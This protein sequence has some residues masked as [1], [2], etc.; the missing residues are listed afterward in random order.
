MHTHLLRGMIVLISVL[1]LVLFTSQA[2]ADD[3]RVDWYE[4]TYVIKCINGEIL[5]TYTKWKKVTWTSDNHP[6]DTCYYD[7]ICFDR[8]VWDDEKDRWDWEFHCDWYRICDH[9][10]HWY[11]YRVYSNYKT[12]T[13]HGTPNR[14]RSLR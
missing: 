2:V 11:T 4:Y 10:S 9:T 14:C 3:D 8:M 5:T 12:I 6:E 7:Y 1:T 13:I